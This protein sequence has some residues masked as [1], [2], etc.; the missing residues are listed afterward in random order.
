MTRKPRCACPFF[1]P[2][3]VHFRLSLDDWRLRCAVA[4]A[5]PARMGEAIRCRAIMS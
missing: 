4:W 2:A 3:I 1:D 5:F